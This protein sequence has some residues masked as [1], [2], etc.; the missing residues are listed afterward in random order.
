MP[1]L[2]QKTA[3]GKG[4][5]A[6]F[7]WTLRPAGDTLSCVS[8]AGAGNGEPRGH[9]R[10]GGARLAAGIA[11]AI[12]I[13]LLSL[14]GLRPPHGY[15][16]QDAD[17]TFALH[18]I[19]A[20][21]LQ[22]GSDVVFTYGPWGFLLFRYGHPDT[23]AV[24]MCG[25][26]LLWGTI[27]LLWWRISAPLET[28]GFLRALIAIVI[29]LSAAVAVIPDGIAFATSALL[30]LAVRDGLRRAIA[31]DLLIAVGLALLAWTKFPFLVAIG[32]GM[33]VALA[34]SLANRVFP[35]LAVAWLL[36]LPL[37][38]LLAGQQIGSL[39]SYLGAAA[40]LTRGYSDAVGFSEISWSASVSVALAFVAIAAWLIVSLAPRLDV[41]WWVIVVSTGTCTLLV[42]KSAFV[43]HD[44]A[45]QV[46]A[47]SFLL[48]VS[49]AVALAARP[50]S[51]RVAAALAPAL[52]AA[53][54]LGAFG[55]GDRTFA[56]GSIDSWKR[57]TRSTL[58]LAKAWI[59]PVPPSPFERCALSGMTADSYSAG[60]TLLISGGARYQ[61]RPTIQ[62]YVAYTPALAKRNLRHLLEAAPEMILFRIQPI[63]G[64]VAH[65]DDGMSWPVLWTRYMPTGQCG[66]F[67]ELRRR[68]LDVPS[69][70][71]TRLG[72][73][74][75]RMGEWILLQ[76][77]ESQVVLRLSTERT[78]TGKL[79]NAALRS[80]FLRIR[81]RF[82]DGTQAS[83]R[84]VERL[85]GEGI[86][87]HPFIAD[88]SDFVAAGW[89]DSSPSRRVV[90]FMLEPEDVPFDG[91]K[92]HVDWEVL[93]LK[94][95][96]R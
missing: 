51:R 20:R 84:V 80:S 58:S 77:A 33:S 57:F 37:T 46:I 76:P 85:L 59:A 92:E 1:T 11:A 89:G 16:S 27:V 23:A 72:Q 50:F 65:H 90:A 74:S 95:L 34:G 28:R 6:G 53:A 29:P 36:A 88:T 2:C 44:P 39:P 96:P 43:R 12:V 35:R 17:W 68:S 32:A 18:E 21:G 63:D 82:S 67:V 61:P 25:R 87:I 7:I 54:L 79:A 30:P 56:P 14:P 73:R 45:H 41:K 52:V 31:G 69:S 83:F 24:W 94:E 78:A 62:S 40:E 49:I 19:H 10:P 8:G 93:R 38:W 81:F 47:G 66:D 75:A 22:F 48:Y 64:R 60:Q 70:T 15:Y 55:I 86:M 26:M 71:S 42:M 3:R 4:R 13:L 9:R 5:H 91:W